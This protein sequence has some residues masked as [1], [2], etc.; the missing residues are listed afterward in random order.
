MGGGGGGRENVIPGTKD[1]SFSNILRDL[2]VGAKD[3][4][5]SNGYPVSK[6]DSRTAKY[7]R[8]LFAGIDV[9]LVQSDSC[10]LPLVH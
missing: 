1:D 3:E 7:G 8:A 9:I 6:E 2:L 10:L 5:M 4:S